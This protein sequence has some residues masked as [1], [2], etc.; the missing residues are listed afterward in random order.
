MAN[1]QVE[2]NSAAVRKQ[3]EAHKFAGVDG[4]E[5]GASSFG[6][7]GD[8]FRRK[9][10]K[11]Q[12]EDTVMR[13]SVRRP[14]IFKDVI[15]H[16]A[17]YTQP[18]PE[19]LHRMLV[20]H[21]ASFI[22]YLDY[23][24]MVT[25]IIASTLP[26]KKTD[27][28]RRLRVVKPSW[29]VDSIAAGKLLPWSDYRLINEGPG[30]KRLQFGDGGKL[31][32]KEGRP[33]QMDGYKEQSK[34]SYYNAAM[35]HVGAV[36]DQMGATSSSIFDKLDTTQLGLNGSDGYRD[37][38]SFEFPD[39]DIDELDS[40]LFSPPSLHGKENSVQS[41][42][43]DKGKAPEVYKEPGLMEDIEEIEEIE[44][45]DNNSRDLLYGQTTDAHNT[46]VKSSYEELPAG[47]RM[48]ADEDVG[49]SNQDN[50]GETDQVDTHYMSSPELKKPA[51]LMTSE[52]HN[53][54]LLADPKLR[55]SSTANP[56][57]LKQ[58]YSESRLHHLSTWKAELKSKMQRL[59]MERAALPEPS[60]R[61]FIMH[62][63]FDSFFCAVSLKSAPPEY[64]KLPAAVAHS[65]GSASEIAS[66]NYPAR[67]FGVKNGMWMKR[68]ME[69][70]PDLKVLSYNF[71]AYEEASQLF[72][73]AILDVGGVVQSV[74]VDEALVDITSIVGD[75]DAPAKVDQIA[76]GL[77]QRVKEKTGCN[78]SVGIGGNILLA[79]LALRRAKPAGQHQILPDD[80]HKVLD[81]L[82]V[83]QLPGVAHSI[84]GKLEEKLGVK[85][86]GDLRRVSKD[87]L[88]TVL[89]PKTG[90]RLYEYARGIDAVEVGADVDGE[91]QTARK[92]VSAEVNWGIRFVNQ[93]EAEEFVLNLCRELERR[94]LNEHVKG[95]SLTMKILRRAAGAPLDPEKHL[96]H[97]KCDVFN[98]TVLFG[99]PTH[100]ANL[101][102][103]ESVSILRSFHFSPGDLRGLGVQLQKLEPIKSYTG[104]VGAAD[105]SQKKLSFATVPL[106]SAKA[107][108]VPAAAVKPPAARMNIFKTPILPPP[109]PESKSNLHFDFAPRQAT[110]PGDRE[111]RD[112]RQAE[113]ERWE[114]WEAPPAGAFPSTQFVM[115]SNPDPSVLA[116]LPPDIIRR[117]V[118]SR[119]G[120]VSNPDT[121]SENSANSGRG[122]ARGSGSS[123]R[124]A[125]PAKRG[126]AP[127][128]VA[129]VLTSTVM[130]TSNSTNYQV[131]PDLP[132]DI[133]PEVFAALPAD[134]RTE[135]LAEY[136]LNNAT[137]RQRSNPSPATSPRR[138]QKTK[139]V[140][141]GPSRKGGSPIK[142]GIWGTRGLAAA[143]AARE[144][145][146][147]AQNNRV[148]TS[149]AVSIV[150]QAFASG[151]GSEHQ[152]NFGDLDPEVL[153]ALPDDVRR[154]VLEDY[155]RRQ[156]QAQG[157]AQVH[158]H[159]VVQ[160]LRLQ[161]PPKK[162]VSTLPPLPPMRPPPM[163]HFPPLPPKMSFRPAEAATAADSSGAR[164]L[165]LADI[166][167]MLRTW[168]TATHEEGPHETDVAVLERYL[169]G[170][171]TQERDMAKA[172]KVVVW[173]EWLVENAPPRE[174]NEEK[175]AGSDMDHDGV[176]CIED[177]Q[178]VDSW[179]YAL[180]RVKA[181][182]QAAME[183]RGLDAM[184]F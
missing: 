75:V 24:T 157:Q 37:E 43:D 52:E 45:T 147:D 14:Q 50:D 124:H 126:R 59:A 67:T 84:G 142:K 180:A 46:V 162:P 91:Q 93:D 144:R 132:P 5:Y 140:P 145:R 113:A 73:E 108:V 134:V 101:I 65:S 148:Q 149:I 20:M 85:L 168:H 86:V 116:E 12:N 42:Q 166:K 138:A 179:Q 130:P 82:Q 27:E 1:R 105:S 161:L 9:K 97:G 71:P 125:S 28:W 18:A 13:Q 151:S 104:N 173:L 47:Q 175:K 69:L 111:R 127:S 38:D 183:E 167:T 172:R 76:T 153:A 29:V 107:K 141:S 11:L 133:D 26:P 169:A 171:I 131:P 177:S 2:K 55:K 154:E 66:C 6:E 23:K 53:R 117:L 110:E 30:Q 36:Y 79:K 182:V 3:L 34:H 92:S 40:S 109:R 158:V 63:D 35:E 7:F 137:S 150:P 129:V 98:K 184:V 174:K 58:F 31:A 49:S 146:H 165:S 83:E 102:G 4:E 178:D 61:R 159:P 25:H 16:V 90:M 89:G 94:L 64:V 74:S 115:P 19:E 121:S 56:D 68:A 106:S 135:V 32:V 100:D 87:R 176:D 8:Y 96:G 57:F 17:S 118:G 122:S 170:V 22:K 155:D 164:A 152:D 88:M 156:A 21:G 54:L 77:R 62:V 163:L 51:K 81:D 139:A 10:I 143:A 72:Y 103:K 112:D 80:I 114:G 128:P 60:R 41:K 120:D 136:R 123:S 95:R 44:D 33:D 70:C 15:A 39:L 78:V 181:A 160:H 99:V 48:H 119:G